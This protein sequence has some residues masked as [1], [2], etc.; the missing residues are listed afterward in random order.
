MITRFGNLSLTLFCFGFL[1]TQGC[2][3]RPE[4]KRPIEQSELSEPLIRVNQN[5]ARKENEDIESYQRRYNLDMKR[6]GTG[7][8]YQILTR[9]DEPLA[10]AEDLATVNF[11]VF[12]L[13][14][15][16]CYSS[17]STGSETFTVDRDDVESGLHEGIKM[18]GKGGK[19]KFILPSHLAHGL[20]G[21]DAKIPSRSPVVY[22]IELIA[23]K[24]R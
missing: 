16:L 8:R 13:D 14:G 15:T 11:N 10:D 19:A 17:D 22:D 24:K 1:L 5:L 7:L 23:L 3:N 20:M 2:R 6:T 21:D 12:L 4:E 18:L 9:G